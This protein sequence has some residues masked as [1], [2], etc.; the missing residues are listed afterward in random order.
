[1]I[2]KYLDFIN[3]NYIVTEGYKNNPSVIYWSEN[4]DKVL[5]DDWFDIS[6][7]RRNSPIYIINF[8]I[9]D[10]NTESNY[11]EAVLERGSTDIYYMENPQPFMEKFKTEFL[12][13]PLDYVDNMKYDPKVLGD[14]GH[15][16]NSNKFN[17]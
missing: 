6:V 15:I 12:K 8:R 3:E 7:T 9:G 10:K 5:N 2:N 1:M 14:L 17:L 11:Y 13:H 16:R 4:V